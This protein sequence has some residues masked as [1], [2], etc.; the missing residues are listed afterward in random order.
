MKILVLEEMI[1]HF[2]LWKLISRAPALL[3]VD[4]EMWLAVEL[5]MWMTVTV[6]LPETALV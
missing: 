5:S 2:G 6:V 1:W 4:V 3:N